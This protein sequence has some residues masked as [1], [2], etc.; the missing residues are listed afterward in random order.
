[1]QIIKLRE[2]YDT[3]FCNETREWPPGRSKY[4]DSDESSKPLDPKFVHM[5]LKTVGIKLPVRADNPNDMA[6]HHFIGARGIVLL[7]NMEKMDISIS[8]LLALCRKR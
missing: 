6:G 4:N 3:V 8:R 7:Y 5:A 2:R 1:M